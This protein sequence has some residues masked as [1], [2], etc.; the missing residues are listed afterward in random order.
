[1]HSM[2]PNEPFSLICTKRSKLKFGLKMESML[3]FR[4]TSERSGA[5]MRDVY[6][7]SYAAFMGTERGPRLAP[8]L[9]N[10]DRETMLMLLERTT[11]AD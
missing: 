6:R 2:T 7:A 4:D 9:A 3:A 1:M 11:T 5:G 8:I 10:C